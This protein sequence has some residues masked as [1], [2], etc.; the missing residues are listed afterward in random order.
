VRQALGVSERRACRTLSQHRS[1]QRKDPCGLPDEQ[2]LTDNIIALTRRFWRYGYRMIT[3]MLNNSRGC[4]Y[5]LPRPV[6]PRDL[7]LMRRMDELH[8]DYPFAGTH[9]PRQ[10]VH[11]LSLHQRAT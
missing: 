11:V 1:S 9:G 6:L 2:R 7:I 3:G 4:V 10:P 5:Y 8:M